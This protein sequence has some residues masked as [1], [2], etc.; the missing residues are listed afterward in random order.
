MSDMGENC[1]ENSEY[2][3]DFCGSSGSS[4]H[5]SKSHYLLNLSLLIY[6]KYCD[7]YLT[8]LC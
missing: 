1:R 6:K 4:T 8:M 3:F 2:V 7:A 5:I